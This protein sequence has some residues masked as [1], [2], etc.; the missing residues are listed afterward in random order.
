MKGFDGLN[1]Q[2]TRA[3]WASALTAILG[4][5]AF[6]LIGGF[7][8]VPLMVLEIENAALMTIANT[9]AGTIAF[10][11]IGFFCRWVTQMGNRGLRAP[12]LD[13][14]PA[15]L[16]SLPAI[17]FFSAITMLFLRLLETLG[18]PDFAIPENYLMDAPLGVQLVCVGLI[19]PIYE[20]FFYR[21]CLQPAMEKATASRV[22]PILLVSTLF[23]LAHGNIQALPGLLCL[24]IML[25]CLASFT[26]S[27]WTSTAL[28]IAYN[29]AVVVISYGEQATERISEAPWYL[30][31]ANAAIW[32]VPLV[33]LAAMAYVMTAKH[34]RNPPKQFA[35]HPKPKGW[36]ALLWGVVMLGSV[37][38]CLLTVWM[39][40][41]PELFS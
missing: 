17:F 22:L 12:G 18:L 16:A 4:T 14:I 15:A 34:K 33:C 29:T 39:T 19:T 7:I 8:M 36:A 32:L 37:V 3:L 21:G 11:G 13:I 41:S 25:G 23:A 6:N 9:I 1:D 5:V 26:G 28:H 27:F 20:E 38:W 31:V 30:L 10:V 40:M 35:N 24:G 2:R